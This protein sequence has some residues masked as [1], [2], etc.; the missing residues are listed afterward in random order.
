MHI[1]TVG[2]FLK[3]GGRFVKEMFLNTPKRK[4]MKSDERRSQL[5]DCAQSLFFKRGF[6]HTTINDIM[7]EAKIS[8]G[9][10]YHHFGSKEELLIGVYRR[11]A[12]E[13]SVEIREI[14]EVTGIS[15]RER[16]D[17]VFE[18]RLRQMRSS[19]SDGE[20]EALHRLY[21]DENAGLYQRLN[22]S[23]ANAVAPHLAR[24]IQSGIDEGVFNVPD[25]FV[26][27]ELFLQIGNSNHRAL[28]VAINAR[29]TDEE[30]AAADY[31]T[32]AIEIQGLAI[33]R[34]LGLPDG[35]ISFRW[36]GYVKE[37]MN[38]TVLD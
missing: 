29:G 19:T 10:F 4:N 13:A 16:I 37:V 3:T 23:V 28:S 26:T 25:A 9:G 14:A 21:L 8:K 11:L 31:L 36:P 33:D 20:I 5:L 17:R 6:E 15:A 32:A 38:S 34:I 30:Q 18:A 12:D 1:Q 24:V 35:S 7:R 22:R 2:R 27:A